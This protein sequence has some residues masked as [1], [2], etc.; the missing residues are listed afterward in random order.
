VG[1]LYVSESVVMACPAATCEIPLEGSAPDSAPMPGWCDTGSAN[2]AAI[3]GLAAA[4]PWLAA[5]PDRLAHA[6]TRLAR[7]EDALAE[8][9]GV[10][11]HG[12][13]SGRMATLALTVDDVP[14]ARLGARLE[15][16][17]IAVSAGLQCAPLAHRA[18]GT[19]PHG[20]V[21]LSAG[22]ETSDADVDEVIL[23]FREILAARPGQ[24]GG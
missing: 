3:V 16:R 9:P 11:F 6:R 8:L 10:R 2:R 21:R 7:V 22:P 5:R 15:E 1:G 23:A 17:G 24:Q 12:S 14:T 18:L 20:V 19:D 13:R 4:L